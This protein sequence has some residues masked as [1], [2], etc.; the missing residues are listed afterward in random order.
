MNFSFRNLPVKQKLNT[1]ILGVCSTILL[2]TFSVAFVSQWFLYQRNTLEELQ[3]LANIIGDNSTAA[4]LFQDRGAL[5][6]NLHSLTRKSSIFHASIYSADGTP[7]ASF[8][9][10]EFLKGNPPWV[11]HGQL[12]EKGSLIQESRIHILAPIILDRET[13]GLIYLQAGVDEIY[14]L[15]RKSAGYLLVIVLGGLILA[16]VLSN[17]LQRIIADPVT[18]LTRAIQGVTTEKNYGLRVEHNSRDEFG[19]LAQG[20]NNMLSQIQ[21]RDQH[22]EEQVRGRTAELH[23]TM[24]K[25]I[26]LADQAQAANRAKSQFLANMSHEIRTPMNGVLGMAEMIMETDLTPEQKGLMAVIQSSGESLLTIINDILD[27]SKIEAGK[28]EI[29]I[30]DFNLPALVEDVAQMLAHRA[31]GKGV[32][33]IVDIAGD[34]PSHVRSDP[35]RIRQVLMNFISNSIKFTDQGEVHVSV[36]NRGDKKNST[37]VGFIVSDTGIG[38]TETESAKL[39]QPFSQADE[40]TTR[41]YGGTGL[42]LAISK[43]LVDLMGG[44]ISCVSQAGKGSKFWFDLPLEKAGETRTVSAAPACGLEGFRGLVIDDNQTN[45]EL[46][47]QHLGGW[48]VDTEGAHDGLEGL[49]LM[50]RAA[51]SGKPFDMVLLDMDMPYM[52]GLAVAR[53]IHK[54]LSINRARLMLLTSVGI[55][56]DV[57][58]ARE[59]GIRICLTK[60]VR[61]TDLYNGL[62]ALMKGESLEGDALITQCPFEKKVVTVKAK[63]LLAE[64]NLINQQVAKGLFGKMGC[65]VDLVVDGLGAVKAVAENSYDIIFMDCQ[66]PV[67]DG[68]EATREIRQR[69]EAQD[70]CQKRA[71]IVALTANALMGDRER[72]LAAGMDDYISKPFGQKQIARIFKKWLPSGV[73][74]AHIRAKDELER[75]GSG[76]ID[77]RVLDNIRGLQ[78]E[79]EEDLLTKIITLFLDDVPEK[80]ERMGRAI[81]EKDAAAIGDLCHTLKSSCA[82]L[83]A[84]AMSELLNKLEQVA[85]QDS[86]SGA[87]GLFMAVELEFEKIIEPLR[88]QMDKS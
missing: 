43:Q 47:I 63:V 36:L 26:I 39:F 59:A 55:R 11:N 3:S 50:H 20:F 72:C 84:L 1:I 77:I 35:S 9:R 10:E 68:Y 62:V 57:H 67:M 21:A 24:D 61:Q 54:D 18:R 37:R 12:K 58:L 6:K 38:M 42:G 75:R 22:L 85:R 30:I 46:L 40:S 5:E 81:L 80:L 33:L 69:E 29:E 83:G 34:V 19:L 31:Q 71:V 56:G 28:L 23:H 16:V 15:L 27:F 53:L 32:E 8:S 87:S 74:T 45:R 66:M 65:R 25:A 14:T 64:D 13:V 51:A 79:G 49:A 4:L 17:R 44:E 41:K 60:P 76:G 88:A 52:D 86:L 82:N 78:A 73:Q 7:M 48:G 70:H 2:L